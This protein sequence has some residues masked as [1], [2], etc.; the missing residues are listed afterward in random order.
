[1]VVG[2]GKQSIYR[3]R[4]GEVEQFFQLPK[5]YRGDDL[6]FKVDWER[7]LKE[8]ENVQNFTHNFRSMKNIIFFNNQF[9]ES[10][11]TLLPQNIIDIYKWC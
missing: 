9:F 3:W 8:H 7:K 5:I 10:V 2:D 4:G 6:M 11:K 1:M